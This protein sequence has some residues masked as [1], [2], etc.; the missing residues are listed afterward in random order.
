MPKLVLI[1]A[2]IFEFQVLAS[3]VIGFYSNGS[4]RKS[5]DY[6]RETPFVHKLFMARNRHFSSVEMFQVLRD[7]DQF[8]QS[9]I[10]ENELIQLGD[11][12]NQL[13]GK[14]P[15]HGSHQNGLDA[16]FVYLTKNKR[17]QSPSASYWDEE[18][19][20]GNK[21]S[22]NFDMRRNILL[23]EFLA[24]KT[25]STRIF[26]DLVIKQEI[27]RYLENSGEKNLPSMQVML[28]KLRIENLHKTHYHLR[29]A[30][31]VG[32]S[33]CTPQSEPPKG[34]GCDAFQMQVLEQA[35]K[36]SSC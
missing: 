30:C 3:E 2:L 34:D 27:C 10:G 25:P 14:A 16:D 6:R 11:L 33:T 24:N 31:P 15:G 22:S 35:Y 17:L 29:L 36:E 23:F 7:M 18:F 12:S 9:S 28:R 4:I 20:V 1:L 8:M 21:L 26:V 13:G 32:S 5:L 19:V